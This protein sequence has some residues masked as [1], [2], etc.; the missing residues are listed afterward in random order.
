[1]DEK[2]SDR[3]DIAMTSLN[4]YYD[5]FSKMEP[6]ACFIMRFIFK[7]L[8]TA[9]NMTIYNQKLFHEKIYKMKSENCC[10][11]F[12][13]SLMGEITFCYRNYYG[14]KMMY[15][16]E[17]DEAITELQ[18]S[19][20]IALDSG[21]NYRSFKYLGIENRERGEVID[22]FIKEAKEKYKIEINKSEC[23]KFAEKIT[24]NF[25]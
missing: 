6:N 17:I 15:S 5:S 3:W 18:N 23:I 12:I 9:F 25:I 19:G 2:F 20:I 1:M 8:Y 13:N 14:E 16:D 21:D 24:N 7:I 10:D 11:L 4:D 22:D